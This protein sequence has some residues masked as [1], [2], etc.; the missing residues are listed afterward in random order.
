MDQNVSS[1][2]KV[3]L[4]GSSRYASRTTVKPKE[5]LVNEPST[6]SPTDHITK[7]M[8][9][10]HLAIQE[11]IKSQTFINQRLSTLESEKPRPIPQ[12]KPKFFPLRKPGFTYAPKQPNHG[13]SKEPIPQALPVINPYWCEGCKASHLDMRCPLV[14]QEHATSDESNN[15]NM[16][17]FIGKVELTKNLG[18]LTSQLR[19]CIKLKLK[20]LGRKM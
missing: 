14:K 20:A 9:E 19:T 5:S 12:E 11:L 10:Q 17:D 2:G 13:E 4:F 3:D 15:V 16:V 7:L 6:S 8:E 18:H 1:L